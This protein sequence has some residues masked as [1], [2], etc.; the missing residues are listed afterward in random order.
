M[1]SMAPLADASLETH[2]AEIQSRMAY[3]DYL[4]AAP[5]CAQAL[6]RAPD[7]IR[8]LELGGDC[9]F[10]LWD[11]KA[12]A[13]RYQRLAALRPDDIDVLRKLAETEERLKR[14]PE[15]ITIANHIIALDPGNESAR[16]LLGRCLSAQGRWREAIEQLEG[17]AAYR[18]AASLSAWVRALVALDQHRD[19]IDV[20]RKV[21]SRPTA[22]ENVVDTPLLEQVAELALSV[23]GEGHYDT[24]R[25]LAGVLSL[26][27]DD[28]RSEALLQFLL[29]AAP[30]DIQNELSYARLLNRTRRAESAIERLQT[31][32]DRI[33]LAPRHWDLVAHAL[34]ECGALA[35]AVRAIERSELDEMQR[36][37]SLLS[38]A[39]ALRSNGQEDLAVTL[40]RIALSGPSMHCAVLGEACDRFICNRADDGAIVARVALMRDVETLSFI[41]TRY[42][43]KQWWSAVQQ[44]CKRL[45]ELDGE[46]MRARDGLEL[47][48]RNLSLRIV[49]HARQSWRLD[50]AMTQV[51][52][53]RYRFGKDG[54][55]IPHCSGELHYE[56]GDFQRAADDHAAG[57]A[58]CPSERGSQLLREAQLRLAASWAAGDAVSG[59]DLEAVATHRHAADLIEAA[60]R[61]EVNLN[62]LPLKRHPPA[63]DFAS[64]LRDPD[65]SLIL[66]AFEQARSGRQVDA[67][68]TLLAFL[69][70]SSQCT[71]AI[72][73]L[74]PSQQYRLIEVRHAQSD[75]RR[76]WKALCE[77]ALRLDESPFQQAAM[78]A[79]APGLVKRSGVKSASREGCPYT[80][81][82][83]WAY[84]RSAVREGE[85]RSI[86]PQLPAKVR[87]P[88]DACIATAGS[89]FAQNIARYLPRWGYAPLL[90]EPGP[91]H[92]QEA[93]RKRRGYGIYSARFGNVYTSLQLLQLIDRAYGRFHPVEDFWDDPDGI[94]D[95]FRPNVTTCFPSIEAL[96][97]DRA[98]HFAAVRRM[99]ETLDVFVFTL[100]L[101]EAW[102]STQDG[103]VF[104]ICPG[105]GGGTFDPA[106][107]Q[108]V[109]FRVADVVAHMS[110]FLDRLAQVNPRARVLLTVSP[111]PLMATMEERHV[112]ASTVC[113]KAILRAAADEL[114]RMHPQV[115]YF[116]AYE[117]ITATCQTHRYFAGDRRNVTEQGVEHV[118]SVFASTFLPEDCNAVLSVPENPIGE[119]SG[120]VQPASQ[121]EDEPVV[122]CEEEQAYGDQLTDLEVITRGDVEFYLND[123][124]HVCKGSQT[125]GND[126]GYTDRLKARLRERACVYENPAQWLRRLV[127]AS[128]TQPMVVCLGSSQTM[129]YVNWPYHC[130]REIAG[131]GQGNPVVLNLGMAGTTSVEALWNFNALCRLLD[132]ANAPRPVM[133]ISMIG[134]TD[135]IY[136]AVRLYAHSVGNEP[137]PVTLRERAV[138]EKLGAGHLVVAP[139]SIAPS[140]IVVEPAAGGSAFPH[141]VF[142][143]KWRTNILE[144]ARCTLMALDRA[145]T[146]A[147]IH[148]AMIL[149]PVSTR[150]LESD[151]A[152]IGRELHAACPPSERQDFASWRRERTILVHTGEYRNGNADA[153]A[154]DVAPAYDLDDL[155]E[156]L[157]ELWRAGPFTQRDG[158]VDLMDM[159]LEA[160]I[161]GGAQSLFT[162]DALH[163]SVEGSRALGRRIAQIPQQTG[164]DWA[165][166][167][168]MAAA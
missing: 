131:I 133:V 113:S 52:A 23:A 81:R 83:E 84:W 51:D 147:G 73:V 28:T 99:F 123:E 36:V 149:Q 117:I 39:H 46:N 63:D 97:A 122:F 47:A 3:S 4:A 37:E 155:Y 107:H 104:P 21:S 118:M 163:Y 132:G 71:S 15:A 50:V 129:N 143:D 5:L 158:C 35:D 12:A 110:A 45:L 69:N 60:L 137:L 65:G 166:W 106:R 57:V 167:A 150:R 92:L 112:L 138:L 90:T 160:G 96:H 98:I 111:V 93:E 159:R 8:L 89:C 139:G 17:E 38:M 58:L 141:L 88:K 13:Q 56:I 20:L 145:I 68:T 49:H 26:L 33:D 127:Q 6:K 128:L 30:A 109:N 41:A 7:D 135:I 62:D 101:T 54:S 25:E 79:L 86:A 162:S 1:N 48:T 77:I 11:N 74:T 85:S 24:I 53:L 22:G 140:E 103:A 80:I 153:A 164:V 59:D 144:R 115:E 16:L 42:R 10:R 161:S 134:S 27:G 34:V 91:A 32:V 75:P 151:Y 95:P 70:E 148:S 130:H 76:N 102:V 43:E 121:A 105:C 82:P 114:C 136:R 100:G 9:A 94:R 66:R 67:I 146:R 126:L 168:S 116:A 142:P 154:T 108:F 87:I 72:L 64:L 120:S 152:R 78:M 19:A 40:L 125:S 2:I 165:P 18:S 14:F 124:V 44:I 156:R 31:L 119:R 29:E 61:N 55:E 157:R